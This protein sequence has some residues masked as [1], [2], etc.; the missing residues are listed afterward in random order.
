[1]IMM[2]SAKRELDRAWCLLGLEFTGCELVGRVVGRLVGLV[3]R[4]SVG[5]C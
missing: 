3:W 1:M 4:V 5:L 2:M